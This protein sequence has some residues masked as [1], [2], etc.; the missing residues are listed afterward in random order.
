MIFGYLLHLKNHFPRL[1]WYLKYGQWVVHVVPS[2][3]DSEIPIN[4]GYLV[5][6][7]MLS[8][9]KAQSCSK[10]LRGQQSDHPIIIPWK[11]PSMNY[12][13][14]QNVELLKKCWCYYWKLKRSWGWL[15]WL[16]RAS[17]SWYNTPSMSWDSHM[18][19]VMT[20]SWSLGTWN[21]RYSRD[22]N[23][24]SWSSHLFA[25]QCKCHVNPGTSL[26]RASVELWFRL[27]KAI[28]WS[29][30]ATKLDVNVINMMDEASTAD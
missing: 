17:P 2:S 27:S 13:Q 19:H 18:S 21:P 3:E 4:V 28:S 22:Q 6:F 15:L 24:D 29:T 9:P 16:F 25:H 26:D 5:P 11:T 1:G 30:T 8:F 20:G 10:F 7:A 23:C 12:C 14:L